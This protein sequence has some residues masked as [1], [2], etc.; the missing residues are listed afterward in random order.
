MPV[1]GQYMGFPRWS[2][3]GTKLVFTGADGG[4]T[5]IQVVA[6]DGSN[7][8]TLTPGHLPDADPAWGP[9]G[10]IAFSRLGDIFTVRAEA[11]SS[12]QRLTD[13]ASEEYAFDWFPDAT[14]IVYTG[15]L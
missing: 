11:P 10:R 14:R 1:R 6:L 5:D 8:V 15:R 3:D 2:P 7:L 4:D 13:T 9:D 12:L